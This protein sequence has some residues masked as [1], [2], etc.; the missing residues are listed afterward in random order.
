MSENQMTGKTGVL[1]SQLSIPRFV[2]YK[3]EEMKIAA[4]STSSLLE[5]DKLGPL[6]K[7]IKFVERRA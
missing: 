5:F 6:P 2:T 1:K 4:G 7:G 3:G